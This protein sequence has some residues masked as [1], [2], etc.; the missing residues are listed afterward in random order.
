MYIAAVYMKQM[1]L[2]RRHIGD[3]DIAGFVLSQW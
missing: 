3:F 1:I 2:G